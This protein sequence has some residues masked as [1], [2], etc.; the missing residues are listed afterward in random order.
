MALRSAD[1]YVR[2]RCVGEKKI[3]SPTQSLTRLQSTS[4]GR[5]APPPSHPH[6]A[7][8][9]PAPAATPSFRN[10]RR[11][12]SYNV[13]SWR[14]GVCFL[15]M[16]G[17][18]SS[19]PS[20]DHGPERRGIH[21]EHEDHVGDGERHEDPDGPEVPVSRR[22]EPAEE[23]GEPAELRRLVDGKPG[24]HGEGAE[25]VDARVGELL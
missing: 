6:A 3:F 24:Q 25:R 4:S 19:V 20:R 21:D 7:A 16:T 10:P 2:A 1:E 15:V 22:L 18:S 8:R 9:V 13:A 23:R 11:S 12:S 14:L 17:E 5:I